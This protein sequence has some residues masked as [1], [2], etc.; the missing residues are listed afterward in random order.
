MVRTPDCQ[1]GGRE[2]E[3]RRSRHFLLFNIKTFMKIIQD[4]MWSVIFSFFVLAALTFLSFNLPQ[5]S[6]WIIAT[7][8]FS[9]V[10]ALAVWIYSLVECWTVLHKKLP[11]LEAK[12]MVEVL[13][14]DQHY[15]RAKIYHLQGKPN[16]AIREFRRIL[17]IN[18]E[19]SDVYYQLGKIYREKGR[20]KEA[21]RFLERYLKLDKEKKWKVEAEKT[22]QA[23]KRLLKKS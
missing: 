7:V 21:S 10:I 5:Y 12:D 16:R 22:L 20:N 13:A 6:S 4:K 2:F 11:I 3:S 15:H 17:S 23:I 9:L 19:D 18:P 8:V 1:S 14:I